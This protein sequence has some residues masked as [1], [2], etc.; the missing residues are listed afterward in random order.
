MRR[1]AGSVLLA[2]TALLFLSDCVA[3]HPYSEQFRETP[4]AGICRRFPLGTDD[5]GRDRLSR[6]LYGGRISLECAPAAAFVSSLLALTLALAGGYGGH[7]AGRLVGVA[8]DLCLS[9]PWLF[10]LLAARAALPLDAP[11]GATVLVTFGLLSLLGWAG[12]CRML[13]AAVKVRRQS[14]FALAAHAAGCSGLRIAVVQILPNLIPLLWTQFLVT[15][16]AF[17]LAEANLGLLGLGVPEPLPS[18]GGML[19]DLADLPNV[20]RHPLALA[21]AALLFVMVSCCQLLVS[22]DEYHV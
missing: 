18:I 17:L 6:L 2:I 21:P 1:T 7:W 13:M 3:P 20:A 5:L 16:P 4:R 22:A 15:M 9:L 14:E 19:R 10:A 8:A 12:P 11:A